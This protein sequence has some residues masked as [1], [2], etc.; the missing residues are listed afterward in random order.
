MES[1]DLLK[2]VSDALGRK[3]EEKN[4]EKAQMERERRELVTSIGKD[5]AES[6]AP[7]LQSMAERSQITKEDLKAALSEVQINIPESNVHIPEIKVPQAQ[8][9]VTVP[10]VKVPPYP[11]VNVPPLQLPDRF[12]VSMPDVNNERPLPVMMMDTK[13]RPLAFPAGATGG[14]SDFIT[15]KGFMSSIGTVLLNPDGTPVYSSGSALG[16]VSVSDIFGTIGSNVVNPDGRLK[17][18]MPAGSSGLTDIELRASSVPVEQVSGSSWSTNVL[19]MPSVT[20]SSVTNSIAT[21]NVDSSGVQYSGSNPFPFRIV[22]DS[23]ATVN[24]VNVDSAGAYRSTFPVSGTV[25]VSA[26]SGTTAVNISDSSGIGYSGSNPVPVT[27]ITSAIVSTIAVGSVVADAVDDGSAPVQHGGIART[28]N[29]TA[30]S[31][32]DVVKATFDDLGRQV[33][34]PVQVRDLMATAYATLTNGTETTLLAASAGSF[35]DLVYIM[36]AN[37]SDAA[38]TVDIRPVT[39]GNI[40]MTLGIPAYGTAG[41]ACPVPYPQ[42]ASDTGNNWT[43]DMGDITG[44][45]V[46]LSGLFTRE[47]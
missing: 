14:K 10:E 41:V 31:G 8:V 24:V 7:Y 3:A 44:T 4:A 22:T 12:S 40:V 6:I 20:V 9:H 38:V 36:G 42:S 43:A 23:T 1:K 21:A 5:I 19:S 37:N 28:A 16:T 46:Y 2:K 29:P 17:V 32:N 15:I 26:V 47:V 33:T 25:A 45:T 30:V 11:T 34:R 18:E 39:S 13:G 27:M 35:H